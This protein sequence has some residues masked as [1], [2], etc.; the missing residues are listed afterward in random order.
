MCRPSRTLVLDAQLLCT[1]CIEHLDSQPKYRRIPS[2]ERHL[3]TYCLRPNAWI[4]GSAEKCTCPDEVP[5]LSVLA[6][7]TAYCMYRLLPGDPK[8]RRTR[9]A[10][11]IGPH[12]RCEAPTRCT[13]IIKSSLKR[14]RRVTKD[15]ID[16]CPRRVLDPLR[17]VPRCNIVLVVGIVQGLTIPGEHST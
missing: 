14:K 1:P 3:L 8:R 12:W 10:R 5:M 2:L 13:G 11:A 17:W 7:K 15:N 4:E 9:R 6:S 16:G